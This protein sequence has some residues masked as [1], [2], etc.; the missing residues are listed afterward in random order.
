MPPNNK[1]PVENRE[2]T[3][4]PLNEEEP[5]LVPATMDY[6]KYSYKAIL[7]QVIHILKTNKKCIQ[8][9]ISSEHNVS[10]VFTHGSRQ[11]NDCW[12]PCVALTRTSV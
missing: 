6:S 12:L 7:A 5:C 8:N 2:E 9:S 11:W 3:N 4:Q 1:D 10:R